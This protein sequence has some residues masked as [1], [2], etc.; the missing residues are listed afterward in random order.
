MGSNCLSSFID[1]IQINEIEN[2][3]RIQFQLFIVSGGDDQSI[4]LTFFSF[5]YD[6][7]LVS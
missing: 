2:N 4:G 1:N 5:Q 3:V 7:N 6:I